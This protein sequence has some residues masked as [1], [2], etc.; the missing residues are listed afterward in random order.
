MKLK[1]NIAKIQRTDPALWMFLIYLSGAVIIYRLSPAITGALIMGFY[2]SMIIMV[3]ARFLKKIK[4]FGEKMSLVISSILVFTVIIFTVY[5]IFPII[6]EQASMLFST[7]KETDISI[8]D[9]LSKMPEPLRNAVGSGQSSDAISEQLS[10]L[11]STVSGF[12]IRF[13]NQA[14]PKIPNIVTSIVIFLIAATY[15]AAIKP[16]F[17]ANLWRFFPASTRNKSIGFV[18]N[19]YGSIKS[20]IGGQ[21]IIALA[22]GIIVGIGMLIAG[23]P[24]AMFMGFLA[25]V[26]NLIPFFGV[27]I[28][29]IPAV[30]LGA[31]NF[32]FWGVVKV[33]I[34]LVAANQLESWVLSPKIQGDRMELN[35]FVILLGI[36]LFGGLFGIVGV[37]FAVPIM[38]FIKDFWI[39]YVQEAF[40]KK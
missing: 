29:A 33:A 35:W 5:Q 16:V 12:G 40:K 34:V 20:F 31:V 25:G 19:Y 24:Y 30:F 39:A 4:F 1:K 3:P 21:L 22:V 2:L 8:P 6:I 28:T 14:I 32:G 36:L 7:I 23:M 9:L 17:S 11:I 26:T 38:V 10:K 27:I 18:K 37:L 15:M 13:I